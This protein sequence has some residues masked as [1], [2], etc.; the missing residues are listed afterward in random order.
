MHWWRVLLALGL[1]IGV[2]GVM[3]VDIGVRLMLWLR[4]RNGSWEG[5]HS[6]RPADPISFGD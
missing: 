4:R 2:G 1:G 3:E 6:Q 5:S